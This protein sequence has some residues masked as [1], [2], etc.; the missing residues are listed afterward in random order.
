MMLMTVAALLLLNL[1]THLIF[2][3]RNIEPIISF[4]FF[5]GVINTMPI[6]NINPHNAANVTT[7]SSIV[8]SSGLG[9]DA[10]ILL[11]TWDFFHNFDNFFVTYLHR[12]IDDFSQ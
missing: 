8:L 6:N 3:T 9:H 2:E 7:I 11:F 12:L 10:P 4:S 1:L 5:L